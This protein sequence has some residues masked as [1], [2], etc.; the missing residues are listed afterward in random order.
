M[1]VLAV[2][3]LSSSSSASTTELT[4]LPDGKSYMLNM[5]RD[6]VRAL[7]GHGEGRDDTVVNKQQDKSISKLYGKL[8][9]EAPVGRVAASYAAAVGSHRF[10]LPSYNNGA[11]L[12]ED[13]DT[14]AVAGLSDVPHIRRAAQLESDK[15]FKMFQQQQQPGGG[16]PMLLQTGAQVISSQQVDNDD[17]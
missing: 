15:A 13:D 1:C 11:A 14:H 8:D 10:Q 5:L 6:R 3:G 9:S 4:E 16:G 2:V 7:R 17:E 12:D